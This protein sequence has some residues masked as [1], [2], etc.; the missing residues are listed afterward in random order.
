MEE[1]IKKLLD[2][3]D[4]ITEGGEEMYVSAGDVY[5]YLNGYFDEDA[6]PEDEIETVNLS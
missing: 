3:L 4:D 2:F 1:R 6:S 5:G